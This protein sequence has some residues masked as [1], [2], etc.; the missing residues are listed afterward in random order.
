MSGVNRVHTNTLRAYAAGA[1][2]EQR[3]RLEKTISQVV[4]EVFFG[5]LLRQMRSEL[6]MSNPLNAG[7]AGQTFASQ[8]DDFLLER[9]GKSSRFSVGRKI[10]EMWTGQSEI[11][12]K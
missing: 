10:A 2:P 5:T 12:E 1:S 11:K 3:A 4:S 6:D 9:L 8:L 7:R